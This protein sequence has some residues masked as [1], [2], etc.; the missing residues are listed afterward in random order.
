LTYGCEVIAVNALGWVTKLLTMDEKRFKVLFL[1]VI[2]GAVL[3]LLYL[4]FVEKS[5]AISALKEW[6]LVVLTMV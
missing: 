3:F 6:Q 2:G 1:V 4:I 5:L